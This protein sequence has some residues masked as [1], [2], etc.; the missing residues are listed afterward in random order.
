MAIETDRLIL[1]RIDPDRDFEAWARALADEE[2]VRYTVGR[3]Q[4]RGAAWRSMAAVIGHWAIRGYGF[5][6]VEDKARGA[7]VGRVGPWF[8][9]GCPEPEIGW[10]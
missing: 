9:E 4:N 2:H 5:F 8:P 6:S 1:R 7:W 3:V 10:S